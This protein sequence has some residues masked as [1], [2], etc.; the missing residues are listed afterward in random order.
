MEMLSFKEVMKKHGKT[1]KQYTP[2]VER[3]HGAHH[4][5]FHE[6]R[7]L[8]DAILEKAKIAGS[9]I[10]LLGEEFTKLR[11]ITTNYTIPS[12]VCESYEAVYNILA[13]LDRAYSH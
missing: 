13:E 4:P 6:V 8:V 5:E 9:G 2:V 11:E 3:V 12:D 10:P 1:L 7:C